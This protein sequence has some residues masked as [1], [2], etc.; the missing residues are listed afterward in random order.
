MSDVRSQGVF[1][2]ASGRGGQG[3]SKA[4]GGSPQGAISP[5]LPLQPI[6]IAPAASRD[7]TL[8]PVRLDA[9]AVNGTFA[10]PEG[11]GSQVVRP[12]SA[13][14]LCAGSIPARASSF[15]PPL[16]Q[17]ESPAREVVSVGTIR[18][19]LPLAKSL[20]HRAMARRSGQRISES[21][22]PIDPE[23]TL[24][25]IRQHMRMIVEGVLPHSTG[26]RCQMF[27]DCS[28]TI[29]RLRPLLRRSVRYCSLLFRPIH[30]PA[31]GLLQKSRRAKIRGT[32]LVFFAGAAQ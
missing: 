17:G 21:F 16:Q 19:V 25:I 28:R 5:T 11:R 3:S 24:P 6:R 2:F 30:R 27:R 22:L 13:K 7:S 31:F 26:C 18:R 14:P 10:A 12:R 8:F 9:D 4:A 1:V 20:S 32:A 29:V 23:T 15:S